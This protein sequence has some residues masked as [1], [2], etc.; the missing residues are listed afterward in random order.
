MEADGEL[1]DLVELPLE[2]LGGA[3]EVDGEVRQSVQEVGGL[4]GGARRLGV[5]GCVQLR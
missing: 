5:F 2:P 3:G 4:R 1:G